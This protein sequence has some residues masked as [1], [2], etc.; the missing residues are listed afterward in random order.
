[1]YTLIAAVQIYYRI[2]NTPKNAKTIVYEALLHFLV[3]DRSSFW[4]NFKRDS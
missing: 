3:K 2:L 4:I 1:M